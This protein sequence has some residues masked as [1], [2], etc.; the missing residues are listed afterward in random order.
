MGYDD[1]VDAYYSWDSKVQNHK[2]LAVGDPIVLW[3]KERLLGVSVIE[4][5]K[6][7]P[8]FKTLN[9]CPQCATTRI[10]DRARSAPRY[11]CM[12]CHAEFEV[13][14]PEVVDVL[15][16]KARYDAA[17]TSLEGLLDGREIRS[18]ATNVRSFNSIRALDWPAF[19]AAL[20]AKDAGRAVDRV[21][22]RVDFGRR[23]ERGT[24]VEFPQGSVTHSFA[25]GEGNSSFA[26]SCWHPRAVCAP[27]RGTPRRASWRRGTCT[28]T[29]DWAR[30]SSTA[31]SCCAGTSIGSST[32][33]CSRSSR[34]GSASTSPPRSRRIPSTR[35]STTNL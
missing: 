6:A 19:C 24:S 10:D 9:R 25:F 34:R 23:L 30:T 26:S 8:G 15:T 17:W 7:S 4:A 18:L 16:Y 32:T 27:S 20:I 1:Q 12:R 21:T 5:I 13:P 31:V 3:D 14:R 35:G 28:A 2:N 33:D 11:R 29:P 22:A